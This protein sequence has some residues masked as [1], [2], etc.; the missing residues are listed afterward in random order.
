MTNY[1]LVKNAA[2]GDNI[3][4][5]QLN[6][7][8]APLCQKIISNYSTSLTSSGVFLPDIQAE[9]PS[10]VYKAAQKYDPTLKYEFSTFV[11][12]HTKGFCLNQMRS[13]YTQRNKHLKYDFFEKDNPA[14]EFG[15]FNKDE[16]MNLLE[17]IK[18]NKTMYQIF[19]IK[20]LE[21]N[22]KITFKEIGL[23]LGLSSQRVFQI[24]QKGLNKLRFRLKMMDKNV[25]L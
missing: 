6:Q 9:I 8:Y 15:T 17:C 7:Q 25:I 24:Y 13:K 14:A 18:K 3:A 11:A 22:S 20:F 19:S 2:A 4:F 1:E 16:M 10:L 21:D 5:N 23:R 12:A